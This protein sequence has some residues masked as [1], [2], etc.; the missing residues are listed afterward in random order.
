MSNDTGNVRHVGHVD[1]YNKE[2]ISGWA[3]CIS[4]PEQIPT[5]EIVQDGRT[6]F[7][8]KPLFY[9][10]KVWAHVGLT[11]AKDLPCVWRLYFPL[12]QGIAAD[13]E[14]E[15][16]ISGS[17]QKLYG[18]N[19]FSIRSFAPQF[20]EI[21]TAIRS[22]SFM[23][24]YYV[25]DTSRSMRVAARFY[26]ADEIATKV[27]IAGQE[28]ELPDEDGEK[29]P[30]GHKMSTIKRAIT[31]DDFPC[32]ARSLHISFAPSS[33]Q[34]SSYSAKEMHHQL[35]RLV[36]PIQAVDDSFFVAP[37]PPTE[38]IRRVSGPRASD[39]SYLVGG[40][41]AFWQLDRIARY[42][43]G[44]GIG[45]MNRV[46]DWGVGCGR[47][48]RQF[49]EQPITKTEGTFN[50]IGYDVDEVNIG[51]CNENLSGLG[52]FFCVDRSGGFNLESGSVDFL[53][54]ISVMTHL[55]ELDQQHWLDEIA[56]VMKPG[57]IVV[58]TTHAEYYFLRSPNS[59]AIPFLEKF[60][61]FDGIADEAIGSER[62]SQY[63]ATFQTTA[64]TKQ[65]WRR[66]FDIIDVIHG[67]SAFTQ[68]FIVMKRV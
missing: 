54:G 2:M 67:T 13:K 42:F 58:L 24:S 55:T 56:R 44:R 36:V 37:V 63:R 57:A 18:H 26:W 62:S 65:M 19:R 31:R 47:I 52:H 15:I 39:L 27:L 53:Y 16:R 8:L 49:L 40:A 43:C 30:F 12:A 1:L 35:R 50:F 4:K 61:F 23:D 20:D 66:S 41:T 60:G 11:E 46:V 29:G 22:Q 7:S 14:V 64:Y 3:V 34:S 51:W 45:E 28:L 38:F 68:D 32:E 59:I 48:A 21:L 25:R 9:S 10:E 6:I 33:L 5:V 17:N